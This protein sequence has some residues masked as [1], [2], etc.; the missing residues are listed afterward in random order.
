MYFVNQFDAA[1]AIFFSHLNGKSA[2]ADSLFGTVFTLHTFKAS[3]FVVV[4]GALLLRD[5]SNEKVRRAVIAGVLGAAL[6]MVLTHLLQ[7]VAIGHVR[8]W[9]TGQYPFR[10]SAGVDTH[11]LQTMPLDDISS[12]PS[13]TL[14][15]TSALALAI[16]LA[17]RAWGIVAFAWLIVIEAGSKLFDGQHYPSDLIVGSI[18]GLSSTSLFHFLSPS[19]AYVSQASRQSC[20]RHP[21]VFFIGVI[22]LGMQVGT[23]FDDVREAGNALLKRHKYAPTEV[24]RAPSHTGPASSVSD[25]E[26]R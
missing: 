20:E 14:G 16:L 13:D 3:P 18:V 10:R 7:H 19:T 26:Q 24:N 5:P 23:L 22:L 4:L 17:S 9:Q 8:P 25:P 12:F 1:S 6:A 15:L 21:M 2:L 11:V